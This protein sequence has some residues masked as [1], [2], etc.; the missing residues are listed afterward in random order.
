MKVNVLKLNTLHG[1]ENANKSINVKN[2]ST[3]LGRVCNLTSVPISMDVTD[4]KTTG[5]FDRIVSDEGG[6]DILF[7]I[8]MLHIINGYA[9]P[10]INVVS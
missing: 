1:P 5:E 7:D 8:N 10:D 4:A 2:D 9:V 6:Y 3:I